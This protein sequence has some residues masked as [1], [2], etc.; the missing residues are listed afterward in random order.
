MQGFQQ[1]PMSGRF[2]TW[3][4]MSGPAEVG[5][6]PLKLACRVGVVRVSWWDV[7][8]GFWRGDS[9]VCGLFTVEV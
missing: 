5:T 1:K 7:R 3:S 2:R 9:N 6:F 4:L 8:R